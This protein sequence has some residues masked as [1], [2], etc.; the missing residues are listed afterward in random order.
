MRF[1]LQITAAFFVL[2]GMLCA[3]PNKSFAHEVEYIDKEEKINM[4]VGKV[5]TLT[6]PSIIPVGAVEGRNFIDRHKAIVE[7][8]YDRSNRT[9]IA[10]QVWLYEV[11]Y[12]LI[13]ALTNTIIDSGVVQLNNHDAKGVYESLGLH[14]NVS[15]SVNIRITAINTSAGTVP[16]DIHL[17]LKLQVQ[18]YYELDETIATTMS[19]SST[20]PDAKQQVEIYWRPTVGAEYYELEWVYWDGENTT[21]YTAVSDKELF[22]QGVRIQTSATHY[23]VD[24]VYPKGTVHFR[25]RPVG[26]F[27]A[28]GLDNPVEKRGKWSDGQVVTLATGFETTRNWSFNRS[29]A[30]EGKNKQV[31]QYFDDGL[32]HDFLNSTKLMIKSSTA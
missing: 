28:G 19:L 10:G 32:P 29:Y 18:R 9:D 24:L 17:A 26:C 25:V 7:L 11:S 16:D 8:N 13:D 5:L 6:D 20:V 30:E 21:A 4:T 23:K 22:E 14:D 15:S 12:D 31:I 27:I 3:L 1:N 2:L